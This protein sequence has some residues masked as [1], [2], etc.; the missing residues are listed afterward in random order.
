MLFFTEVIVKKRIL[1]NSLF[2]SDVE[3]IM[4]TIVLKQ[5]STCDRKLNFR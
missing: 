4:V 5:D 3:I 1:M 2:H